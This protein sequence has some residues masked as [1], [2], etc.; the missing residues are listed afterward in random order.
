VIPATLSAA[1]APAT[2]DVAPQDVGQW[3]TT[4]S[5]V[6]LLLFVAIGLVLRAYLRY[7]WL[8]D[9]E[10]RHLRAIRPAVVGLTW[11]SVAIR[12]DER[13]DERLQDGVDA[14]SNTTVDTGPGPI[15]A[16]LSDLRAW[17][18][19][20]VPQLPPLA[21]R[22]AV[23]GLAILLLGALV[24]IPLS[25][26]EQALSPPDLSVGGGT[27]VGV[28]ALQTALSAVGMVVELTVPNGDLIVA[29]ALTTGIL[30]FQTVTSYWLL[31]GLLLIVGGVATA[32]LNAKTMDDLTVVLYPDRRG[33]ILSALTWTVLV[34]AVAA[35]PTVAGQAI[36]R[37][38]GDPV[39]SA[40]GGGIGTFLGLL[41][42][43]YALLGAALGFGRRLQYGPQAIDSVV[44]DLPVLR[45]GA[46]RVG[47]AVIAYRLVRKVLLL[48]AVVA[49][50]VVLY[51]A[52]QAV[53]TR[54]V[55][56]PVIAFADQP[57][58]TQAALLAGPVGLIAY[59]LARNRE[60]TAQLVLLI[61]RA[62]AA[63]TIQSARFV[64]GIPIFALVLGFLIGWAYVS[65]TVGLILAA[66][67][68]VALRVSVL[69]YERGRVR[70]GTGFARSGPFLVGGL[71]FALVA[72]G[73]R[74]LLGAGVLAAIVT[75]VGLALRKAW[76]KY[77]L[78]L[79]SQEEP[80][81]PP[82]DQVVELPDE[83]LRDANGEPIYVARVDGRPLARRDPDALLADVYR[84]LEHRFEHGETPTLLAHEYYEQVVQTGR[85]DEEQAFKSVR[86]DLATRVTATLRDEGHVE[87]ERLR[88]ELAEYYPE[89]VIGRTLKW[90]R[91]RG[92]IGVRDDDYVLTK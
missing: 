53:S 40:L 87:R 56:R 17:L 16:G 50:P 68:G 38:T 1:L 81:R 66:V 4:V 47:I 71:V 61:R 10:R 5:W 72:Y 43:A 29:L 69:L 90:L 62:I 21:V 44:A 46:T 45:D 84:V 70:A 57:A 52:T 18:G 11:H 15:R 64:Q 76:R 22:G 32:W 39:Y 60:R 35:L 24:T 79:A 67:F 48:L 3:Q 73:T 2:V 59:A 20:R 74:A 19:E 12:D 55:A 89:K 8:G 25:R 91:E 80:V 85:V 13:T 54:A 7:R 41:V 92:D 37:A 9:D 77:G 83:P 36:T 65:L 82:T 63:R 34:W 75:G 23:E 27:T 30:T 6:V 26:W 14:V 58:W 28:D 88:D 31:I 86:G 78:G 51:L 49:V 33:A 42:G